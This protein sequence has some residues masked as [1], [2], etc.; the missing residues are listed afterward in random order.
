MA[1]CFSRLR[2]QLKLLTS[3]AP[4]LLI[5]NVEFIEQYHT[6][7]VNFTEAEAIANNNPQPVDPRT[8]EDC[9][10]IDVIFPKD[11]SANKE[12]WQRGF[13]RDDV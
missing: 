2:W 12:T 5:L 6:V 10:I 11:I 3:P 13:N 8:I 9:L 7:S 4:Q 1:F